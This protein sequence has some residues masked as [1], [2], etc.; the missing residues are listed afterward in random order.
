MI[1][2]FYVFAYLYPLLWGICLK[3]AVCSGI[4]K[5]MCDDIN[6]SGL[7]EHL[8]IN[9]NRIDFMLHSQSFLT[10]EQRF[11]IKSV[12]CLY[13]VKLLHIKYS[14]NVP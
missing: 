5:I 7:N 6:R 13:T 9:H 10:L 8:L 11:Q 2:T 4:F 1:E 12:S 3:W 14:V